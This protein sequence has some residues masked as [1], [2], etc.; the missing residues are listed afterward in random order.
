MAVAGTVWLVTGANSGMGLEWV[1]QVHCDVQGES[2][3]VVL[4]LEK[5][6]FK[7]LIAGPVTLKHIRRCGCETHG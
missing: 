5:L 1:S 6:R 2:R 3:S 7:A 4:F